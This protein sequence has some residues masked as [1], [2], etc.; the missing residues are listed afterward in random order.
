MNAEQMFSGQ[1][2]YTGINLMI[3]TALLV[4]RV[5]LTRIIWDE[6]YMSVISQ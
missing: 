3:S 5:N 4:Y 1:S 6:V 2:V